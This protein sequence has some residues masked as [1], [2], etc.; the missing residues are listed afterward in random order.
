MAVRAGGTRDGRA[1]RT[2]DDY[3]ALLRKHVLPALG[4]LRVQDVTRDH[5]AKMH[6]AI[7]ATGAKRRANAALAWPGRVVC[8]GGAL[9]AAPRQSVPR[10]RQAP[11]PS[12]IRAPIEPAGIGTPDG[13]LVPMAAQAVRIASI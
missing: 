13:D 12:P 8:G 10:C 1:E 7:T 2:V 4:Q 3:S 11:S 6:A 5:I 9:A